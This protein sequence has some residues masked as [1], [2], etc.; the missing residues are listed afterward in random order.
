MSA[1][2]S[3]TE[4]HHVEL[5]VLGAHAS[6]SDGSAPVSQRY[7]MA[8]SPPVGRLQDAARWGAVIFAACACVAVGVGVGVAVERGSADAT[9]A[10]RNEGASGIYAAAARG[11]DDYLSFLVV[12]D[13]GR[14][15]DEN[16]TA[17]ARA[18]GRCGEVSRPDFVVS[19][20]DN[21]YEGGLNAADDPEFAQSFTDVYTH[22][23]LQ[24]PWHAILGNHDYGDCGYDESTG[25]EVACPL[26]A[27]V[28]RSPQFQLDPALRARD[29]RWNAPARNFDLRP[30]ADAHLF[31]I[32]TNPHVTSYSSRPW[33]SSVPEGLSTQNATAGKSWLETGLQASNARWKLVF[34][35][36]P[37][38]SNGYWGDVEDVRNSLEET[39]ATNGVAAYFNG[40]DH[41][42]QHTVVRVSGRGLH[43]FTS[44]AGSKTGRGFGVAETTFERD[45]PGFAS[46]RVSRD[47]VKVQFWGAGEN[48][49]LLHAATVEPP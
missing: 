32:D 37:M 13:W 26:H 2:T 33:A 38:R 8:A 31:F 12:G 30:V 45:E 41:D 24:V 25:D 7:K 35:H 10:S 14:R 1:P 28:N 19:V 43:H 23:T 15:G 3:I 34:G 11:Q 21:F 49:G 39:L 46:V 29:W 18:M 40:H 5:E 36:H 16:Q 48:E 27:D 42:M 47:A 20:G 44:G 9:A 22:E 4:S 17:V 6:K